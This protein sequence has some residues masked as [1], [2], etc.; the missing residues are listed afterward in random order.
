[1][2]VT[3]NSRMALEGMLFSAQL[4]CF[5]NCLFLCS[6]LR[7]PCSLESCPQISAHLTS[8]PLWLI[9][10]REEPLMNPIISSLTALTSP[11]SS[12]WVDVSLSC[13]GD[14]TPPQPWPEREN[15][16]WFKSNRTLRLPPLSVT[17]LSTGRE[18]A[19]GWLRKVILTLK[20]K[21]TWTDHLSSITWLVPACDF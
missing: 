7:C 20:Q 5:Q 6:F 4:S 14:W 11:H 8:L 16:D 9:T 21:Y 17:D 19:E 18:S 1:M 12:L 2:L 15:N 3:P 10:R 13:R